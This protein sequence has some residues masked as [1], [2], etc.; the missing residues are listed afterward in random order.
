MSTNQM[1]R[2]AAAFAAVGVLVPPAALAQA[3]HVS[4]RKAVDSI[5]V[6][7]ATSSPAPAPATGPSAIPYSQIGTDLNGKTIFV[8]EAYSAGTAGPAYATG[9]YGSFSPAG[10]YIDSLMSVSCSSGCSITGRTPVGQTIP[11]DDNFNGTVKMTGCDW[12]GGW[13]FCSSYGTTLKS[14]FSGHAVNMQNGIAASGLFFSTDMDGVLPITRRTGASGISE[15]VLTMKVFDNIGA[16]YGHRVVGKAVMEFVAG[17]GRTQFTKT[18]SGGTYNPSW[19]PA[20][21]IVFVDAAGANNYYCWDG[22]VSVDASGSNCPP[23]D[24]STGP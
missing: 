6:N 7:A 4:A 3:D 11:W 24:T 15:P 20:A 19:I 18:S 21:N 16:K 9:L 23:Q 17:E 10:F 1:A 22:S 5:F 12:N 13:G 8:G 14:D 2:V